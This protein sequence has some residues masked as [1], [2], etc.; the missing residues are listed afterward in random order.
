MNRIILR[1]VKINDFDFMLKLVNDS[2]VKK[3][4]PGLILDEKMLTRWIGSLDDSSNE[5]IIQLADSDVEIGECSL[6]TVGNAVEAGLMILPEYWNKGYGTETVGKLMEMANS[7][8]RSK[9]T[10]TTDKD[11]TA[12]I[13][14]LEKNGF[15]LQNEGFMW[16]VSEDGK[17]LI[18]DGQSIVTYEKNLE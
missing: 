5:Y 9:I 6:S 12:M 18:N 10:A 2:Q 7:L 13:R 17:N 8:G 11:N 14:I 16:M 4:L 1:P 15:T 3:Y